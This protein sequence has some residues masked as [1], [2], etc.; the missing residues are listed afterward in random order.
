MDVLIDVVLGRHSR[1]ALHLPDCT[2]P[3]PR[4]FGRF[5]GAAGRSL[6]DDTM[7]TDRPSP[8]AI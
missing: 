8:D 6:R 4:K 1:V 7:A 2:H 5:A 3:G